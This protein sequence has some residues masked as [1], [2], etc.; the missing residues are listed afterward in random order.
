MEYA[1]QPALRMMEKPMRILLIAV[2]AAL[3]LAGCG[4]SSDAARASG[5]ARL[6]DTQRGALEKAKGVNDTLRQADQA[7]RAQEESQTQ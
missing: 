1:S 5:K 4:R 3:T 6:Y 7:R 2:I